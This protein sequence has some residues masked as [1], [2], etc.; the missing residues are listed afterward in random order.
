MQTYV[1]HIQKNLHGR[2][3]GVMKLLYSALFWWRAVAMEVKDVVVGC[4]YICSGLLV[5]RV[6]SILRDTSKHQPYKWHL[7]FTFKIKN[8]KVYFFVHGIHDI[9]VCKS[10]CVYIY[11]LCI[12]TYIL[13]YLVICLSSS[14]RLLFLFGMDKY[15]NTSY[16]SVHARI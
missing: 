7:I 10:T 16:L 5:K 15:C 11:I 12:F 13:L 1:L 9:F 6:Y 3:R 4:S 14:L 8:D 2:C